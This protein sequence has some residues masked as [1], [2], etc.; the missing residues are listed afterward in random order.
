M[1]TGFCWQYGVKNPLKY[2]K[3]NASMANTSLSKKS[4]FHNNLADLFLQNFAKFCGSL[5]DFAQKRLK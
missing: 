5:A 4:C 1:Q 3:L 2:R